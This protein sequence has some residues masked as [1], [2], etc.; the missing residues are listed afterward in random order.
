MLGG[1]LMPIMTYHI[2]PLCALLLLTACSPNGNTTPTPKLFKE[3]RQTLDQ[4][5]AID[6][7][8]QQQSEEQRKAI[9]QQTQ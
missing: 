2:T 5:K 7:A 6:P 9:E 1:N 4:A 8:Q 3:Q